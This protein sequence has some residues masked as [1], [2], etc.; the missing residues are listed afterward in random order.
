MGLFVQELLVKFQPT[1]KWW[2][3]PDAAFSKNVFLQPIICYTYNVWMYIH[4]HTHT[5]W[6]MAA[7]FYLSPWG[8]SGGVKRSTG[9]M[10]GC[11]CG[12]LSNA[13]FWK[14]PTQKFFPT[15]SGCVLVQNPLGCLVFVSQNLSRLEH[16][17][18]LFDII[19]QRPIAWRLYRDGGRHGG[20]YYRGW[21]FC[22]LPP[23]LCSFFCVNVLTLQPCGTPFTRAI[24]TVFGRFECL[25]QRNMALGGGWLPK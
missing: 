20:W 25:R 22:H 7:T 11:F 17:V 23:P 15:N 12:C 9:H 16:S 14:P 4:T 1:S 10:C 8:A 6:Y 18:T 21:G 19:I 24:D 13:C 2:K 5:C 3:T